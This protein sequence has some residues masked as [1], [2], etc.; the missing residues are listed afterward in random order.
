MDVNIFWEII[1]E[2]NNKTIIVQIILFVLGFFAFILLES[3]PSLSGYLLY[4]QTVAK[5]CVTS[6]SQH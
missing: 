2:Y 3:K 4:E 1:G 6:P 5:F